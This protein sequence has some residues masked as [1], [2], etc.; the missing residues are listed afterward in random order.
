MKNQGNPDV[1]IYS[2]QGALLFHKKGNRIDV[3]SLASGVY[4]AEVNGV[5]RK[6]V[7]Q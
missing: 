2:I 4:I 1:K 3:S 5:C 6:I 7:K